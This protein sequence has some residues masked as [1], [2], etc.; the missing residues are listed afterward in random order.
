MRLCDLSQNG[1]FLE[2]PQ[3]QRAIAVPSGSSKARPSASTSVIG[4][5]TL[6]GPLCRT[7]ISTSFMRRL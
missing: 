3:R 5:V 1:L 2:Y 6:Y 7:L 4:P